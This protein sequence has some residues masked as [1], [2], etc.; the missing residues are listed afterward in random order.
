MLINS[1]FVIINLSISFLYNKLL[2]F[3]GNLMAEE[4]KEKINKAIK[5]NFV[6][7]FI[8]SAEEEDKIIYESSTL[9]RIACF[10]STEN[11]PIDKYELIFIAIIIIAKKWNNQSEPFY[12]FIGN[13]L[14]GAKYE[15][16][17]TKFR[18]QI[19]K[20]IDFLYKSKKIFMLNYNKKYYATILCHSFSPISSINSFLNLCFDIYCKDLD[21]N[22]IINDPTIDLII[23]SLNNKINNKSDDEDLT[24]NSSVYYL[25]V[26][27]KG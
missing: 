5:E 10:K 26:G 18:N 14:L 16:N 21:Q 12:D 4:L 9:F 6:G 22:F 2:N 3:Q 20:V 8:F 24:L 19:T 27:I 7:N 25:R 17:K 23:C 1:F 13:K 11:I 15:E